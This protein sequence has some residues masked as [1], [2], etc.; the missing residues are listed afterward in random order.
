MQISRACSTVCYAK[1]KIE[2]MLPFSCALCYK[3]ILGNK[4]PH[5]LRSWHLVENGALWRKVIS[6]RDISCIKN[7]PRLCGLSSDIKFVLH[8]K[9]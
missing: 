7:S 5:I 6:N 8:L 4:A 9:T 2:E 3:D 1:N